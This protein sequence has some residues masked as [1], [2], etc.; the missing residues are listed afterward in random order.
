MELYELITIYSLPICV[1][2]TFLAILI[3]LIREIK[4]AKRKAIAIGNYPRYSRLYNLRPNKFL[5][6]I[7]VLTLLGLF[8]TFILDFYARINHILMIPDAVFLFVVIFLVWHELRIGRANRDLSNFDALYKEI[9]VLKK[10]SFD[11]EGMVN[12]NETKKNKIF[13]ETKANVE[14]YN[15]FVSFKIENDEYVN[16]FEPL[17][18]FIESAHQNTK[19]FNKV[20]DDRFNKAIH[21]FV[22]NLGNQRNLSTLNNKLFCKQSDF[23]LYFTEL[24]NRLTDTFDDNFIVNIQK[25]TFDD[26]NDYFGALEYC[27]KKNIV[28]NQ[29]KNTILIMFNTFKTKDKVTEFLT[30]MNDFTYEN[31]QVIGVELN[32]WWFIDGIFAT[33]NHTDKLQIIEKAVLQDNIA[34]VYKLIDYEFTLSSYALNHIKSLN[35]D[36]YSVRSIYSIAEFNNETLPVESKVC[37]LEA[38]CISLLS[39]SYANFAQD[40]LARGAFIESKDTINRYYHS[41]YDNHKKI[42][43]IGKKILVDFM[44]NYKKDIFG[45]DKSKIFMLFKEFEVS[46]DYESVSFLSYFLLFLLCISGSNYEKC[47]ELSYELGNGKI[48]DEKTYIREL[49]DYVFRK[50]NSRFKRVVYRIESKRQLFDDLVKA[51]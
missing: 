20:L 5:M 27:S 12:R 39:S 21:D 3:V 13:D 4:F 16:L 32:N 49:K 28:Y 6:T 23:D 14:K 44:I 18:A 22:Y 11:Y 37:N 35:V 1:G 45:I 40:V 43:Q 10:E 2:L 26:E 41:I 9:H 8:M 47:L 24:K 42:Y 25:K 33:E 51:M 50:N 7:Y 46:L 30:R 36:N 48:K 15:A 31:A 34:F 17:N 19:D 29:N 38:E